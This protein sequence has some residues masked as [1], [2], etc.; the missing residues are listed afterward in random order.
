ML[1][2]QLKDGKETQKV[3]WLEIP[4]AKYILEGSLNGDIKI[5]PTQPK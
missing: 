4:D 3:L 2:G 1:L 5:I